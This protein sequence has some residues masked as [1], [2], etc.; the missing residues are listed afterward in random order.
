M[1]AIRFFSVVVLC[2][3]TLGTSVQAGPRFAIG[4]NFGFPG[5]R[6]HCCWGRGPY[7][8]G[9][10]YIRPYPVYVNQPVVVREVPVVV[11]QPGVVVQP[12]PAP[13]PAYPAQPYQ[14][15]PTQPAYPVPSYRPTQTAP[16]PL[17]ASVQQTAST[18]QTVDLLKS[19]DE[20]IRSGAALELGRAKNESAVYALA[21]TLTGDSSPAVREAA[22]RAL[23]LIGSPRG[24]ASLTH[25]AQTD[26]DRDVRRTAQFAVEIIQT[27]QKQR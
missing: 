16:A 21:A 15:S 12:T 23:G 20:R 5:Y 8:F 22:A 24:L 27:N 11:Q 4:V 13:Q 9:Y 3:M 2:L 10:R 18:N 7:Y 25:A 1:K 19:P 6:P 14:Q 17:A 26:T